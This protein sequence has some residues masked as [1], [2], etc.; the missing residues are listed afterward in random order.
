MGR[1]KLGQ[2]HPS[3]KV[4]PNARYKSLKLLHRYKNLCL[5][6]PVPV[7][8]RSVPWGYKVDP[9]NSKVALPDEK[10]IPCFLKAR[11]H[12]TVHSYEVVAE[13]LCTCGFPISD[14]GLIRLFKERP[15]WPEIL[16]PYEERL[17]L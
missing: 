6:L 8:S 3:N 1:R 12:L 9:N 17:K 10:A 13:W 14:D 11:E 15:V 4:I 16:L 5:W 7:A 2:I